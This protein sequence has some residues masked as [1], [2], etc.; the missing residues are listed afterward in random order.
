MLLPFLLIHRLIPSSL[1][2][3]SIIRS[4]VCLASFEISA[5]DLMLTVETLEICIV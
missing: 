4:R 5:L 1:L 3:R 2:F